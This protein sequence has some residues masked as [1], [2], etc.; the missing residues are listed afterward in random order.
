MIVTAGSLKLRKVKSIN[1]KNRD[2]EKFEYLT[3]IKGV[4]VE[5]EG[6]KCKTPYGY[7]VIR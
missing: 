1:S 2:C 7:E 5:N 3:V 6:I 4:E